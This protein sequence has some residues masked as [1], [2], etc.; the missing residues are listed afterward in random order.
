[1]EK[2]RSAFGVEV[3]FTSIKKDRASRVDGL[4]A[5]YH[6]PSTPQ[7][8]RDA[9]KAFLDR[10][11]EGVGEPPTAQRVRSGTY[12]G[13]KPKNAPYDHSAYN[14]RDYANKAE[15]EAFKRKYARKAAWRA[16]RND[17]NI[18]RSAAV[19]GATAVGLGGLAYMDHRYNKKHPPKKQPVFKAVPLIYKKKK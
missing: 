3:P 5:K 19:M 15:N 13:A 1:M 8:E 2:M 10:M 17:P 4:R 6:H 18:R 7:S 16:V 14:A 11:G 9:A 12:S